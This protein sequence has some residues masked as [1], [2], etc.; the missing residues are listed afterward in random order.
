MEKSGLQQ[1]RHSGG[2]VHRSKG[3]KMVCMWVQL[4]R[5]YLSYECVLQSRNSGD[6]RVLASA[7]CTYD[8]RKV[9]LFFLSWARV[10]RV[11][12]GSISL[13]CKDN[14]LQAVELSGHQTCTLLSSH[15]FKRVL[16]SFPGQ[17]QFAAAKLTHYSTMPH[18]P[19]DFSRP[20]QRFLLSD[21]THRNPV[22]PTKY[23]CA[24]CTRNVTSSGVSYECNRSGWVYSKWSGLQNTA[25]YRQIKIWAC[26][27]C[28]CPSTPAVPNK[29]S[30]GDPFTILQFNANVI[31]NK[32][33]EL[34]EFLERQS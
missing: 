24:M 17:G 15:P 31:G 27:S 32:Q 10:R 7:L 4:N 34:G 5:C 14:R 22:P 13:G 21:N 8:L 23:T 11:R 19:S 1:C 28:S 3:D 16:D 6:E 26:S 25:E 33:V 9:D 30:D 18:R 2:A 12:R 29:D 20:R